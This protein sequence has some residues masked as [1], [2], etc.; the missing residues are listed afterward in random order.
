MV[1][2]AIILF[3]IV[4][5]LLYINKNQKQ[6]EPQIIPVQQE[7]QAVESESIEKEVLDSLSAPD[8]SEEDAAKEDE[9]KKEILD[10]LSV[11]QDAGT[12]E[13]TIDDEVLKSLE[14]PSK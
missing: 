2:I 7:Q 11:S 5:M 13:E 8:Q 12:T 6:E 4:A 1:F 3:A 9:D 10:S 14:A